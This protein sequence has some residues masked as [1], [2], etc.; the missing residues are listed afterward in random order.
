MPE[1][2]INRVYVSEHGVAAPHGTAKLSM[3]FKMR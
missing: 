3:S 1:S 2:T